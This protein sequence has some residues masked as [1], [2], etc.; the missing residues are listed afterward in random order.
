MI[1]SINQHDIDAIFEIA[2]E[3]ENYTLQEF[4]KAISNPIEFNNGCCTA[5]AYYFAEKI[6]NSI[7]CDSTEY[8]EE[9]KEFITDFNYTSFYHM[10]LKIDSKYYDYESL[11]GVYKIHE[12]PFFQRIKNK[13]K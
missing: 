13:I 5:F 7:I 12:L 3:E 1:I 11:S 6:S 4:E 2:K 9:I 8:F 10:F